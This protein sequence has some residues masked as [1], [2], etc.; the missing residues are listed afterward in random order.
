MSETHKPE[1]IDP[2]DFST[3]SVIP[4]QVLI[5]EHD[6]DTTGEEEHD[7]PDRTRTRIRLAKEAMDKGSSGRKDQTLKAS[8]DR[9]FAP[10][11]DID[12][13]I[14]DDQ[15]ILGQS[16]HLRRKLRQGTKDT[17]NAV[18]QH[19]QALRRLNPASKLRSAYLTYRRHRIALKVDRLEQLVTTNPNSVL[20]KRREKELD[21]FKK[22]L[23]WR[24]NQ[25]G[26][27]HKKFTDRRVKASKRHTERT[28]KFQD[29][30]DKYI[31]KK[32]E[33]MRRKEQRKLLKTESISHLSPGERAKYL[34]ELPAETKKRLTR[35]AI[36]AIR[37]K[38]IRKGKLDWLYEVDV[39]KDRRDM[40]NYERTVE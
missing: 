32:I 9:F 15:E 30:I 7:T 2:S 14:T 23:K 5:G 26:E 31:T 36:L 27:R 16:T 6:D 21:M 28:E 33:A 34:A 3:D 25:I 37:E 18:D 39:E 40:G 11:R 17:M 29:Q 35:E 13:L 4:G 24:D 20:N 8:I 10:E 22:R 1:P 12:H 38:N 19:T